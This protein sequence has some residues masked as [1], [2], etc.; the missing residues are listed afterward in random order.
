MWTED[1]LGLS[2]LFD[3]SKFDSSLD[4]EM[5]LRN[6]KEEIVRLKNLLRQ[7]TGP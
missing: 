1:D 7:L 4:I 2:R 3:T 6:A 5:E